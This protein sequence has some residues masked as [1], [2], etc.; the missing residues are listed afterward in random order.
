MY[1]IYEVKITQVEYIYLNDNNND[2]NNNNDDDDN[3]DDNNVSIFL[4]L[5]G[6]FTNHSNILYLI[7]S[8]KGN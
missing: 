3:N 1:L 2:D 4:F 5:I 6:I 8:L 7:I